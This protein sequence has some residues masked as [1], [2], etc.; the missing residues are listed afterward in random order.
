MEFGPRRMWWNQLHRAYGLTIKQDRDLRRRVLYKAFMATDAKEKRL[1]T[2][3]L[4]SWPIGKF[5]VPGALG[6]V[7][8]W[9]QRLSEV[10]TRLNPFSDEEQR[11]LINWGYALADAAVR[12]RVE[13]SA[14]PPHWPYDDYRLD[15]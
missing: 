1:G 3:W 15:A 2:Y 10:R 7:D 14:I 6:V 13:D 11:R 4:I 9:P 12:R 5:T 8:H